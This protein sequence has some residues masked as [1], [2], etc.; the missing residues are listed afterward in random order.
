MTEHETAVLGGGGMTEHK[1]AVLGGNGIA[2]RSRSVLG[3]VGMA[4]QSSSVLGAIEI[5]VQDSAVTGGGGMAEHETAVLGGGGILVQDSVVLGG[6]GMTDPGSIPLCCGLRPRQARPTART[7]TRSRPGALLCR[8]RGVEPRSVRPKC[9]FYWFS[10]SWCGRCRPT[11]PVTNNRATPR[12]ATHSQGRV[13]HSTAC[14]VAMM[15]KTSSTKTS[16][17]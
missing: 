5:A 16:T 2:D 6:G 13:A 9:V 4:E 8:S 1:T 14:A 10:G 17:G 7:R 3:A 11:V 15:N 12:N